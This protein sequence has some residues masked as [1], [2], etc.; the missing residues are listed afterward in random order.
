MKHNRTER[1][2]IHALC[3]DK[4]ICGDGLVCDCD[5]C[6]SQENKPC[7]TSSDCQHGL[8]CNN[9]TCQKGDIQ[10]LPSS[11]RRQMLKRVHFAY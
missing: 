4:Q 10:S 11:G 1:A 6:K 7:A 2:V 8:V 9:W 3:N 5:R